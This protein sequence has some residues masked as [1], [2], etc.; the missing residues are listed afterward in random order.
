MLYHSRIVK[1]EKRVKVT[2]DVELVKASTFVGQSKNHKPKVNPALQFLTC[3][4]R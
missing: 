1:Q 2:I 4:N 3:T